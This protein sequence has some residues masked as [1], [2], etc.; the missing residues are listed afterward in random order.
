MEVA[1][2]IAIGVRFMCVLCCKNYS[3]AQKQVS[4]KLAGKQS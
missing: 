3:I 2:K 1:R 4:G